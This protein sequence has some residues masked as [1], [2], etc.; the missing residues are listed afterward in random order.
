MGDWGCPIDLAFNT[1][2]TQKK[3]KKKHKEHITTNDYNDTI[4]NQE[5]QFSEIKQNLQNLKPFDDEYEI[6]E[7]IRRQN[8]HPNMYQQFSNSQQNNENEN[9]N[10]RKI[11]NKEYQEYK[12]YK[13][14]QMQR[15]NQNKQN[16]I[17][18]S[19]TN[20]NED[21]NDI[22]LFALTGIFFIIFTDYIYKLGKKS[23]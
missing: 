21:F 16:D 9:E 23:I 3:K 2:P 12:A 22:I 20:I 14:Y 6:Y 7:P 13:Q 18:E 4:K 19:F 5:T 17:I 11:S 1:G 15:Y 8:I 10:M